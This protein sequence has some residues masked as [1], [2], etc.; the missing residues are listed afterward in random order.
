MDMGVIKGRLFVPLAA[1]EMGVAVVVGLGGAAVSPL[2]VRQPCRPATQAVRLRH[3]AFSDVRESG[4]AL[5][6]PPPPPLAQAVPLVGPLSVAGEWV[7]AGLWVLA[8]LGTGTSGGLEVEV[9]EGSR[10]ASTTTFPP[11]PETQQT[12]TSIYHS[13]L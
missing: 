3:A 7:M 9:E 8:G 2:Q 12:N 11:T 13:H 10:P 4:D 5:L 6:P 1:G